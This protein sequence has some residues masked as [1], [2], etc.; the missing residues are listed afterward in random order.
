MRLAP[1]IILA[2]ALSAC[3]GSD[4]VA[5]EAANTDS[6]PSVNEDSAS[7]TGGPPPP[8]NTVATSETGE[9]SLI[10]A[11][12]H[13]RWGPS[14]ADC[15][16][17]RGDAKGLLEIS[18]DRLRFYESVAVPAPNVLTTETS[19]GGDFNFTGEGQSWTKY[20][21]LRLRGG[22]LVRTE[23]DPVASLRYVRCD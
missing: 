15:I 16:S 5:T 3:G 2:A 17:T 13:G 20:Q 10:P 14:P 22:R 21:S 4:P 6:L 9:A 18:A 19:V 12:I 23:R 11:A 1:I 8:E 7:P